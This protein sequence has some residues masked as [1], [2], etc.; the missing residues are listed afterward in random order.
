MLVR[1]GPTR[2]PAAAGALLARARA[3]VEPGWVLEVATTPGPW[4]AAAAGVGAERLGYDHGVYARATDA[5]RLLAA[6]AP[7]LS[8]RL[9]AAHRRDTGTLDI[10][11]YEATVRLELEDG[12]VVAVG[13]GPRIEDPFVHDDVGVAPDLLPALVLGRF[14]ASGLAARAD[15]VTLGR[16]G[17]LCDVLFPR[18]PSDVVAD[19]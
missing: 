16:H 19:L 9:A 5:V 8:R 14:G 10:T 7:V 1:P 17:N 18:L 2:T 3:G 13:R 6:S 11:T 12:R 15:D 4:A